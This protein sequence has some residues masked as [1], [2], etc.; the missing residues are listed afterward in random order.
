MADF[1]ASQIW[2]YV[3]V[4][5]TYDEMQNAGDLGLIADPALRAA[6]EAYCDESEVSQGAW[7]F[8]VV[9]KYGAHSGA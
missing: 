2:P 3:S 6:L 8:G 5:R 4:R 1:Q 7:I 9:S